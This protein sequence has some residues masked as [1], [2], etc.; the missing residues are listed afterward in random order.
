MVVAENPTPRQFTF[1]GNDVLVPSRE[2]IKIGASAD[3]VIGSIFNAHGISQFTYTKYCP[4]STYPMDADQQDWWSKW[5]GFAQIEKLSEQ[6]FTESITLFHFE[7][8]IMLRADILGVGSKVRVGEEKWHVP[9]LDFESTEHETEIHEI[10]DIGLPRGV[11]LKTDNSFHY[12]GLDLMKEGVWR[13]WITK[14]IQLEESEE[15]FG[16]S[17]LQT[18]LD[19]GYSALRIWGYPGTSKEKSP[20]VVNRI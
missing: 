2:I 20:V 10:M 11:V 19:R 5:S 17:Y 6:I 13:N 18:C 8:D 7:G 16:F 15:L 14:L 4:E 1:I 3:E 12:Y 9:M